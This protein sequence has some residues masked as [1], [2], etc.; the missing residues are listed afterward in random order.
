MHVAVEGL[1]WQLAPAL[2]LTGLFSLTWLVRRVGPARG[3]TLPRRAKRFLAVGDG[4][5]CGFK[6]RI[7]LFLKGLKFGLRGFVLGQFRIGFFQRR[8][9]ALERMLRYVS[10]RQRGFTCLLRIGEC[11]FKRL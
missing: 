2:A 6:F 4:F 5:F 8:F 7:I 3:G 10:R 9:G 11:F 1:R